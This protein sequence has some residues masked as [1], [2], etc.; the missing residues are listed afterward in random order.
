MYAVARPTAW[1]EDSFNMR[2]PFETP[3]TD[4]K[5]IKNVLVAMTKTA[6]KAAKAA[7]AGKDGEAG[8]EEAAAGDVEA[9]EEAGEETKEAV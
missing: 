1:G 7:A 9:K 6:N 5:A 4:R 2:L 3:A 8:D